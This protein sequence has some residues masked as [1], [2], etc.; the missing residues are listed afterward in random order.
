MT[1]VKLRVGER[2]NFASLA[3]APVVLD[4]TDEHNRDIKFIRANAEVT[5]TLR[6]SSHIYA[7]GS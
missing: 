5:G 2:Y 6:V 7:N 4:A 3:G 1:Q